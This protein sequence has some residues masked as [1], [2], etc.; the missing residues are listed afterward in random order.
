MHAE[1]NAFVI[2]FPVSWDPDNAEYLEQLHRDRWKESIEISTDGADESP[3]R[4]DR[5]DS[6][7]NDPS[8]GP[9]ARASLAIDAPLERLHNLTETGKEPLKPG[10]AA[11]VEQHEAVWRITVEYNPR[12]T[13][14]AQSGS[15]ISNTSGADSDGPRPYDGA[16]PAAR[17]AARL[18]ATFTEAGSAGAFVP[19]IQ[20]FHGSEFIR[21]QAAQLPPPGV[22]ATNPQGIAQAMVNLFVAAWDDTLENDSDDD[23]PDAPS[24]DDDADDAEPWM[25]TR[26]LTS[27]GLPELETRVDSGFNAAYFRLLD[28]SSGMI[29]QQAPYP[30]GANL[31]LGPESYTLREGP[32]GPDD[33]VVP[34]SGTFGVFSIMPDS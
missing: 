13:N 15:A 14:A 29:A 23:T 9:P 8:D 6:S 16:L 4:I 3:Q 26:G 25:M 7:T 21:G 5:P 27:F 18:M 34:T 30:V 19:A 1:P 28:V 20:Q 11:L 32:I 12:D 33:S 2:L 17:F 31:Q 10:E 22:D 24:A